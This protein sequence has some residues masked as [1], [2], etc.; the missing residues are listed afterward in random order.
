MNNLDLSEKAYSTPVSL[1]N[2]DQ[3]RDPGS[4]HPP[5]RMRDARCE[6]RD[7]RYEIH[8]KQRRTTEEENAEAQRRGVVEPPPTHIANTKTQRHEGHPPTPCRRDACTTKTARG[9]CGSTRPACRVGGWICVYLRD[10]RS[11]CVGWV[12]GNSEFRIPNCPAAVLPITSV[13]W[14]SPRRMQSA[15]VGY[16]LKVFERS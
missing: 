1:Q 11:S 6:I 16:I 15:E 8:P 5:A 9:A 3:Y 2:R 13:R 7:T 12:G 10:L 4:V 14:I